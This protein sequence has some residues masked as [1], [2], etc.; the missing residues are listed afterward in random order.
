VSSLAVEFYRVRS[1]GLPNLGVLLLTFAFGVAIAAPCSAQNY[2][3]EVSAV[4]RHAGDLYAHHDL[5]GATEALRRGVARY[6]DSAQLH[7]MLGNAYFRGGKWLPAADEYVKSGRQRPNHPDTF[8][9]LGYAYYRAGRYEQAV[10]AW[11]QAVALSPTDALP[12]MS[13]GLGL[14]REHNID[15][16]RRE[17]FLGMRADPNWRYRLQ[18]DM[19]CPH[20]MIPDIVA[21]MSSKGPTNAQTERERSESRSV[22]SVKQRATTGS[23][24]NEVGKRHGELYA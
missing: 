22:P 3:P 15:E 1:D 12:R 18:I 16:A 21:A 19:R 4:M 6:P 11:N 2:S 9:S 24:F 20:E 8:L 7:F 13:L 23:T 17:F 14:L 10:V 5:A